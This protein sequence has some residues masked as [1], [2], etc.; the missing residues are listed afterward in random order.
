MPSHE[1]T[2]WEQMSDREKFLTTLLIGVCVAEGGSIALSP[3]LCGLARTH[4][5]HISITDTAMA[6]WVVNEGEVFQ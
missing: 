2:G 3:A 5:L 4:V 1:W 6:A